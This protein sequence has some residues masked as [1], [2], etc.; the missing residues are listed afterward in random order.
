MMKFFGLIAVGIFACN[1]GS[2]QTAATKNKTAAKP[3]STKPAA[4]K[5]PA[6]AFVDKGAVTGRTYT[7]RSLGFELTFPDTWV[8]PGE[9]FEAEMKKAGYDL[10]LRP[11]TGVT[12]ADRARMN[13]ALK[14]VTITLTAYRSMQGSADNAIVR[15]SL[16][17]LAA[18]PQIKDAVDYFDAMRTLY[19]RMTLP[20]DFKYSETGAEQLGRRQFAFLDSSS[21]AGK[22]R[23]YATVRK[24]YAVLFSLSYTRDEDVQTLRQILSKANFA[25]K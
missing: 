3:A 25:L 6:A 13:R 20:K 10:S 18:N 5:Q 17:S 22:K 14:N 19:K 24:G 4:A 9:D 1:I 8:I 21:S 12:A 23:L 7:N 15:I 16:E 11:P 2:G